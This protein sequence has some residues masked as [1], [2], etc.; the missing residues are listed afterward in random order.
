MRFRPKSGATYDAVS[1]NS[2]V[3]KVTGIKLG[4]DEIFY[5]DTGRVLITGVAVGSA[6]LTLKE[7]FKGKTKVVG[8]L[9]I[10]VVNANIG[11]F[12]NNTTHEFGLGNQSS[13]LRFINRNSNAT[14]SFKSDKAGLTLYTKER[15]DSN[16]MLGIDM[17]ATEYGR[18]VVAAYE[19]VNGKTR[20]IKDITFYIKPTVLPPDSITV[21][22][23]A[24]FIE[25]HINFLDMNYAYGLHIKDQQ[26]FV[27]SGNSYVPFNWDTYDGTFTEDYAVFGLAGSVEKINDL[28]A[29]KPT[30][31]TAEMY[32]IPR[33]S[34]NAAD[35]EYLKTIK[36]T[37]KF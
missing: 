34:N 1:D 7:T 25:E 14:Y 20:K 19:T 28:F 23:S 31:V 35:V 18:Y 16:G 17:N 22:A 10:T 24:I 12:S 13:S 2:K 3:V 29:N 9:K 32:R 8:K 21:K 26:V 11:A 6:N 27:R 4:Y 37:F 33:F 30:T 15:Y 36:V 5:E